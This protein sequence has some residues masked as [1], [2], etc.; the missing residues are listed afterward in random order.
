MQ[1]LLRLFPVTACVASFVA[2]GSAFADP[3]PKPESDADN[4]VPGLGPPAKG[5]KEITATWK[6]Q[7]QARALTLTIP[8]PRG[9]I[10]DRNGEPLAQNRVAQYLALSY[11]FFGEGATD[12]QV[13][14]FAKDRIS[15]AAQLLGKRWTMSDERLI[16]H[17]K[18]RRWLPLIFSIT[19][20]INDELTAEQQEKIKPLLERDSA[21]LLQPTYIRV[22]PK[23]AFASHIIG[24]AGRVRQLPTGPVDDG[25]P[26]FEEIEGKSGLEKAFDKDLQ[27]RPGLV[28]VLFNADGVRIK[29]EVLRHPTP[30]N[31]VVTTLDTDM[32]KHAENALARHT[33]G[34][35]MVIMDV[36][37]GDILAMASYPLYDL[38]LFIPAISADAFDHL[39]RDPG[40]PLIGR[41]FQG[42]YPPASTFKVVVAEA[43][44]ESGKINAHTEFD[45]AP[46][47]QI[48]DHVF[49]NW[50]KE[51]EGMINVVNA[52]ERSCNT[53]F[54]QAGL[55]I[56]SKPIL[57]MAT[58]LGFGEKTG[59]PV[60][61]ENSGSIPTDSTTMQK[62]GH[63]MLSGDIANLSI[64]QGS[65]LVT[66]LQAAQAMAGVADGNN[67]PQ[68]R[69]VKQVQTSSDRVIYVV[70]PKVRRQISLKPN[71]RA[72]VLK[73]MITVVNGSRGTGHSAALEQCQVA[74]KTGTAQWKGKDEKH[75]IDERGL[76]WFTGFLPAEDPVYAFAM[77]YEGQPGEAVHG[78]QMAGPVVH[79]VFDNYFKHAPQDDPVLVKRNEKPTKKVVAANDDDDASDTPRRAEPVPETVAAPPPPKQEERRSSPPG[80][81]G[82]FFRRIFGR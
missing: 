17:Y 36:R 45:G 52:L 35:A 22:Y 11:P 38:N 80:G 16:Q 21:L 30:G 39:N 29:E 54:Y 44:L 70:E 62:L 57:D 41:A 28:N 79:E 10:V 20:G 3:Q 69:L 40:D 19:D 2:W 47:L 24:Y 46:S 64:G 67:L 4:V 18:N 49:H 43:A 56:G 6:S 77:V 71:A 58:R 63:K 60:D 82:G 50:T 7:K 65:T 8:G 26:L 59:I 23:G 25:Q 33:K 53:W 48:G 75:H 73:G 72:T 51:P 37:N 55:A 32:Q 1:R 14:A 78:G 13:L 42:T 76:A 61:A 34:G 9:Q 27:G 68:P 66:P 5:Q 81:I 74:G 31:N 12:A 15:R